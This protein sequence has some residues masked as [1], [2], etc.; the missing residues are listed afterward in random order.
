MLIAACGGKPKAAGTELPRLNAL[1]EFTVSGISSGA[2]LANQLHVAYSSEV[3]GAGL[4]A[5]GPWGC[6]DGSVRRALSA[7]LTGDEIDVPTLAGRARELAGNGLVD[8]LENLA[9][10]KV[11]FF[12]GAFDVAVPSAVSEKAVAW[13]RLV[14][15][16][17][18]LNVVVDVP[19]THGWPTLAHGAP[20]NDFKEPWINACNYDTAGVMLEH[21]LGPLDDPIDTPATLLRFNQAAFGAGSMADVGLLFVPPNCEQ[22]SRC[23]VHVFLHGCE[24]SNSQ[25]GPVL[26]E[27]SGLLR[28]AA[29]NDLIV[30]FPQAKKSRFFPMNPMSCWDWWGYTGE[31]YLSKNAAQL[32]GIRAM[33][34]RLQSVD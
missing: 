34:S 2:Y 27:Q 32:Q 33:V 23:R 18:E 11:Y 13:Y 9:Q 25:I 10:D 19:V 21:L 24:Q 28:W 3:S 14:A 12:H 5:V 30:L 16:D 29:A 31:N 6:A 20:C 17:A 15:P 8:D 22:G 26:A 7:C 4:V 1:P